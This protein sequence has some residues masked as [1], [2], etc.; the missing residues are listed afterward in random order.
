MASVKQG[1]V[2]GG[3]YRLVRALA[4]GGMGSVWVAQHLQLDSEVAVKFM[5]P[6]Y[7][8]SDD[9]RA[10]FEREAKASA[11]LK[12]PNVVQV[13]DYGVEDDTPYIVMELLE[14]ED[15]D[16]R[17]RREGRLSLS[18][19]ARILADA[20]KALRRAHEVGLIHRDLKPAN[21]F[22]TQQGDEVITKV[23]DFGI[24]KAIGPQLSGRATKT[25]VLVGSPYY[26]SPEQIRTGKQID[27]RT[28]IWSL[29]VIAFECITGQM[30][31]PSVEVGDVLVAICSDPIPA[32]SK[33]SLRL[34]AKVDQFFERAL[35]R[36]PEQRFQSTREFAQALTA[37]ATSEEGV[38]APGVPLG[39]DS[40]LPDSTSKVRASDDLSL[41]ETAVQDPSQSPGKS[42]S[43]EHAPAQTAAKGA[44]PSSTLAP[45]GSSL[46]MPAPHG[47][48]RAGAVV[49]GTIL[50]LAIGGGF[51]FVRYRQF[52]LPPAASSPDHTGSMSVEPAPSP[53]PL[54]TLAAPTPPEVPVVP[55]VP[56]AVTAVVAPPVSASASQIGKPKPWKRP[57]PSASSA[58]SAGPSA[59]P[60]VS[61]SAA[62][63]ASASA[64]AA[65]GKSSRPGTRPSPG[66]SSAPAAPSG[67][68]APVAPA[69]TR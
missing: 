50:A 49:V 20:C 62:P 5:D 42:S 21:L 64:G 65:A 66:T 25:G 9:A 30:P 31:F 7:I 40:S 2:I 16:T 1:S 29:G 56:P 52:F 23:L 28:D 57:F 58:P 26:M 3:K 17:L 6:A 69:S 8:D 45:A 67:T 60:A 33:I 51:V 11:M 59:A 68:T 54:P 15:L 12:S 55:S 44:L 32:P 24:A 37:L 35:M 39:A 63:A 38:A 47:R 4:Q 27:H 22:L 19:T 48:R 53:A 61:A 13:Y 43:P 10:R 46:I 14:G 34:G 36:D 18:A 41:A